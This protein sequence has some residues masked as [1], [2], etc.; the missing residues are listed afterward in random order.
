[1]YFQIFYAKIM[2]S[3][4]KKKLPLIDKRKEQYFEYGFISSYLTATVRKLPVFRF[5][6]IVLALLDII[7]V[8]PLRE[9]RWLRRASFSLFVCRCTYIHS[10]VDPRVQPGDTPK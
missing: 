9:H 8:T 10:S 7:F 1:M 2:Q 5:L 6:F 4:V 3:S